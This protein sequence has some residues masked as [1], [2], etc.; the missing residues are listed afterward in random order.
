MD[1]STRDVVVVD[2]RQYRFDGVVITRL[3]GPPVSLPRV[4]MR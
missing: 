2:N 1:R 4:G 3:V